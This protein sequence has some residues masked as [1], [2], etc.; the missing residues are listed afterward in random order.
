[1]HQHEDE[2]NEDGDGDEHKGMQAGEYHPAT[3]QLTQLTKPN[4]HVTRSAMTTHTP[5]HPLSRDVGV[6]TLEVKVEVE[7][8]DKWVSTPTCICQSHVS[9]LELSQHTL[10]MYM[11]NSPPAKK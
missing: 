2:D 5:P 8:E 7:H 6:S 10:Y 9:I 4:C 1:M 11:G 3:C